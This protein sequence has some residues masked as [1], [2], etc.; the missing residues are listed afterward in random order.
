MLDGLPPVLAKSMDSSPTAS[1][2]IRKVHRPRL[3]LRHSPFFAPPALCGFIIHDDYTIDHDY[4]DQATSRSATSTLT[5]RLR[6]QQ[7][8]DNNSSQ[9]R[10]RR[11]QRSLH[12][13]CDCGREERRDKEGTR[14][15][16]SH[17][18]RCRHIR[19]AV[20]D[21]AAEKTTEAR[22]FKFSRNRPLHSLYGRGE[23]LEV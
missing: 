2:D 11:H 18:P 8:M 1:S 16:R 5:T 4:F 23:M 13:R 3:Q 15:G 19:D 21:G 6:L 17:R 22:A 14:R 9:Q 10:P 7:H 20:D 12:S